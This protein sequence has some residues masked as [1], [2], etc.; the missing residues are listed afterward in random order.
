MWLTGCS[1]MTSKYTL[2]MLYTIKKEKKKRKEKSFA[3]DT[4]KQIMKNIP[5]KNIYINKNDV[6]LW[7]I[8]SRNIKEENNTVC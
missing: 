8:H 4:K 2:K 5:D 1:N 7:S 3:L 6:R